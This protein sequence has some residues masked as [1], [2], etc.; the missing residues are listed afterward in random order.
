MAGIFR[1]KPELVP[2]LPAWMLPP[3]AAAGDTALVELAGR[4]SVAAA[5]ALAGQGH[6]K[7]L[8]PCYAYTGSEYGAFAEVERAWRRLRGLAPAGV[9]VTPLL[10]MGSP[11]FWR[12]LNGRFLA[13]LVRRFGLVPVCVGCHLYLHALRIPLARSLGAPVIAG[14]RERHDGRIKLNQVAP[15]L[16]AYAGLCA[17]FGVELL[18]PLRQVADG[19]RVVEILGLDWPEGGEQLGCALS[20]NY[21]CID[22]DVDWDPGRLAAYLEGFAL[23]LARRVVAAWLAG[24]VPDHLAWAKDLLGRT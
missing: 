7:R 15:A 14:E 9:E 10:L 17:E 22:G 19:G 6:I 18:L 1:D 12:A 11:R 21:V 8:V 16:D 2:P 23:P 13:E 4:D 3:P 24:R 5:L 20:G